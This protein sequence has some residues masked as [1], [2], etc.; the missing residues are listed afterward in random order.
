M[1]SSGQGRTFH[2]K[3]HPAGNHLRQTQPWPLHGMQCHHSPA[4]QIAQEQAQQ[5]GNAM[6]AKHYRQRTI[7]N[8]GDL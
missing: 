8:G 1:A 6:H 2:A 4:Q 7:H 3:L 5:G